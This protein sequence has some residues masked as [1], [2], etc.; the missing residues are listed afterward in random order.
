MVKYT[1]KDRFLIDQ[2]R[3]SITAIVDD[4]LDRT[5]IDGAWLT[6][7][8]SLCQ[9]VLTC[10]PGDFLQWDVILR[11]MVVGNA[12]FVCDE[13]NFLKDLPDWKGRWENAIEES[14]VGHPTFYDDFPS[15]SGNLIT[16]AYH[17]AQFE[18]KT[19]MD[20]S[21]ASYVF[22]FGGGYG[23]MC[24]L[25]HNLNF[26]GR[27]VIFDLPPLSALQNFFLNMNNI[28]SINSNGFFGKT[29]NGVVCVSEFEQL[30]AI[31]ADPMNIS[32]AIFI[33]TWSLS[34]APINLRQSILSLVKQFEAFLIGYQGY[35]GNIDNMGFFEEWMSTMKNVEWHSWKI[36]HLPN[37]FYRDN[38]YL[39]GKKTG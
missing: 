8:D 32:D 36:K 14:P 39:M 6:N 15:S 37:Q 27:Y 30:E 22:E 17:L 2:L 11:T 20:I 24:R 38:Y 7:V 34:E 13:L 29:S 26:T 4:G 25:V 18:I 21:H 1:N 12:E 10:D 19:G 23:S 16:Q 5:T 35:F 33:A 28:S 3:R 9:R 31:L